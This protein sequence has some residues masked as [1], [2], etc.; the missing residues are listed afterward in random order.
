MK[1][2]AQ[3]RNRLVAKTYAAACRAEKAVAAAKTA[4]E[5]ANAAHT[6][7]NAAKDTPWEPIAKAGAHAAIEAARCAAEAAKAT[8]DWLNPEEADDYPEVFWA[9][10]RAYAAA[11]HAEA[12]R[13]VGSDPA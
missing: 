10:Q 5:A 2:T 4:V 3:S 9:H 11:F 6:N 13:T 8:A 12:A 1:A 7:Q